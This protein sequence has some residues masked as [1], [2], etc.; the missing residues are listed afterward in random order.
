MKIHIGNDTSAFHAGSKA[1]IEALKYLINADSHDV[2]STPRPAPCSDKEIENCDLLIIN[3]EGAMQEEQIGWDNM[4]ARKLMINLCYAKLCGKQA[5]L[6]N[7][8]W[9]NMDNVWGGVL[10]KLD[11]VF[12]REPESQRQMKESTGFLPQV[13]PD[14]SYS[15]PISHVEHFTDYNNEIVIGDIY[16]RNTPKRRRFDHTHRSFKKM[17]HLSLGGT[18]V[19]TESGDWSTIIHSLRTAKIYVT[20]QHHGVY[21]A[22]KARTPFVTSKLYNRKIESLLEWGGINLP[23]PQSQKEIL[24]AIKWTYNNRDIFE[25][26]FDWL[27]KQP[28]WPGLQL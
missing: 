11:G 19:G 5:Y 21:A 27:E 6:V 9:N 7:S 4:R 23:I 26:F 8:V 17:P 10:S 13:Y 24:K 15:C 18:S 25:R 3:G 12:V 1:V 20:G 14:L 28:K 22:C 2:T 16:R